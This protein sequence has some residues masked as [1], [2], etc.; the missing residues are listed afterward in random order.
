M[1]SGN[2]SA[3]ISASAGIGGVLLGNSFLTLKEVIF[4]NKKK[5]KDIT[6]LTIIV[7][8]HLERFANGCMSVA[9]DD[10]K[11]Y[12]TPAGEDGVTYVTT[13]TAPNFSPLEIDVE[14][15][16]LPSHLL[17]LILRL[18][19]EIE[20]LENYLNNILKYS[21][22]FPENT[23]FFQ[24]RRIGYAE[25]G[26]KASKISKDLFNYSKLSFEEPASN[27]WDRDKELSKV[28]EKI[29]QQRADY[30]NYCKENPIIF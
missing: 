16:L 15:K 6:Y 13:T 17:Y 14:W 24:Q 22:D 12:G 19:D 3:I 21:N 26:L 30:E 11:E 20:H 28:I 7:T 1:D 10:G 18:P 27:D 5:K 25:L 4:N 9:N 23:E 8:S 29:K 2:I